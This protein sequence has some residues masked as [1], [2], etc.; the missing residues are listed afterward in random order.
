MDAMD[1]TCKKGFW[2]RLKAGWYRRALDYS[3]FPEVVLSFILPRT[4]DSKTFIDVG[5]GCGTLAI[6]LAKAGKRVTAL[7]P[8]PA[9]M[10]ILK[11]EI[12]RQGIRN[13]KPV[14]HAWGE[15]RLKRHDVLICA[16]VPELLKD[17]E[18]FLKEADRLARRAVFLIEGVDPRR[19]KFY[20]RELYP[21]VFKKHF[22]ER[23]DY[24]KTY[25]N[26]HRQGIFANVEIIEY[27]FDQ[28][29][30]SLDEAVEFWKEY[31]GIV[32]DEHNKT[33]RDFLKKR[34]EKRD[35][36]FLARFHKRSAIVWWRKAG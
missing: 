12:K 1:R 28:P 36:G 20:Y 8:S 4:E 32:T 6:P 14:N 19:D 33:L 2:N 5:C 35:K 26:L 29:F 9:M 3:N 21:L 17:S 27:D 22:P 18:V 13:I 25:I 23:S 34:L 15:V 10:E 7:D 24:L 16:N 11:E 31:M 30:D